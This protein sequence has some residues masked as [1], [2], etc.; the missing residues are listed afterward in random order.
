M[1]PLKPLSGGLLSLLKRFNA[2]RPGGD[3]F[4]QSAAPHLEVI[5]PVGLGEA[6]L[7]EVALA[8]QL[9]PHPGQLGAVTGMA[10]TGGLKLDAGFLDPR[11]KG[12]LGF[13]PAELERLAFG[14]D[15]SFQFPQFRLGNGDLPFDDVGIQRGHHVSA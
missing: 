12:A 7:D 5:H 1:P 13:E 10:G 4:L 11:L 14:G 2:G 9:F 15:L 3:G 6:P 8:A